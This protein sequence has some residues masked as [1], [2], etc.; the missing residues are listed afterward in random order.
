M[1]NAEPPGSAANV[2]RQPFLR[3]FP[4]GLCSETT[5]AVFP[6]GLCSEPTAASATPGA[7]TEN[8]VF[9]GLGSA[10]VLCHRESHASEHSS[11]T[12]V[13]YEINYL[14][15]LPI[16]CTETTESRYDVRV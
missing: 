16:A 8:P 5:A 13:P 1:A 11:G 6:K 3:L 12:L 9:Y 10:G 2:K 7:G 14:P 4:K 15:S